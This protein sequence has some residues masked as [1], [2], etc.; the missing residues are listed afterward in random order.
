MKKI[1]I[2]Y[3]LAIILLLATLLFVSC[4][5]D[6]ETILKDDTLLVLS[7][8]MGTTNLKEK[9]D[10]VSIDNSIVLIF[11][12]SL[13]PDKILSELELNSDAGAKDYSIEFSNT[14]ST[15]T[16]TPTSPFNYKTVYTLS[17]AGGVYGTGGESL[18]EQIV[19]SFTTE[20]FVLPELILTSNV[21]ELNEEGDT[22]MITAKLNKP[23]DEIVTADLVF[24]GTASE[25]EDY[26]IDSIKSIV[27]PAGSLSVSVDITSLIDAIIEGDETIRISVDHIVNANY[28]SQALT[29]IIKDQLPALSLKGVMALNWNTSGTNGGKAIHLVANED[30][31]DLSIYGIGV[32]NNGGGT[33]G[34]EFILPMQSVT[35]GDDILVARD[36][37]L[38]TAYFGECI[39]EFEHLI[40][41]DSS[42]NQNGDDAIELFQEDAVIDTFGDNAIDGTGEAWEYSDSWTY[43]TENVWTYGGIGCTVGSD[44]T[45]NSVCPYPICPEIITTPSEPLILQ[46]VLAIV[47]DGSGSNGGK[48]IHLKA[49]TA[50]ADLSIYSIGIANNG[51]GTDGKEYTFPP[52][53]VAKDDDILL[54]REPETITAYFG[55]CIDSFEH[56]L[57]SNDAV[58]Q[59]GDDAIELFNV[60]TV[61]ETYGDATVDGTGEI[62]EYSGSWAYKMAGT[63]ITGELGC[64]AGS[65]TTQS[66]SC[67][68]PTCN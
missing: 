21:S 6:E 16:L 55:S 37:N 30:I 35:A 4:N 36:I 43:K 45:Q 53:S 27:I 20:A 9:T 41:A 61:V 64:A 52:I 28:D 17:L 46:G 34:K 47:W 12:H 62:W 25:N 3:T 32:A 38:I 58:A 57:A 50:I 49:T 11:S 18:D 14:N 44:D 5:N 15:I 31:A 67:V 65:T 63:W 40:T 54:A 10:N 23:S 33:D 60:D 68:Y 22:A 51:G 42:I 26:T 56:V 29:I 24:T 7:K 59:N 48:A 66:S 13:I 1:N 39:T 19:I 2:N 8:T